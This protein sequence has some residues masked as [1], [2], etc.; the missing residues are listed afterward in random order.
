MPAYIVAR[1][2]LKISLVYK[3]L[4][5]GTGPIVDPCFEGRLSI[6]LH[7]LT[8]NNYT[9]LGGDTL[10]AMEF[11]K[12]SPNIVWDDTMGGDEQA[13][14]K[15][16]SDGKTS[17][18]DVYYYINNALLGNKSNDIVNA[19][20]RYSTFKKGLKSSQKWDRGIIIGSIIAFGI[21]ILSLLLPVFTA[22]KD[23]Q[24]DRI[25]YQERQ[26]R[27]EQHIAIL[28]QKLSGII[29]TSAGSETRLPDNI[30][31]LETADDKLNH[32]HEK[33]IN[34]IGENNSGD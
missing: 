23:I 17:K 21:L 2:N 3:G 31:G 30:A 33:L 32:Q 34:G 16:F 14:A 5:L 27:L 7:N 20:V 26:Y 10:I 6:P 9:L 29:D 8:H 28:E 22:F 15:F 13:R 18:R 12:T 11:T 1:F 4:L 24:K 25:E 19:S